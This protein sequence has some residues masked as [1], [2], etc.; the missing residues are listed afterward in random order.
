MSG[1]KVDQMVVD[2]SEDMEDISY[3]SEDQLYGGGDLIFG[4]E[5][6]LH[7]EVDGSDIFAADELVLEPDFS[8]VGSFSDLS[9][10]LESIEEKF[11][12]DFPDFSSGSREN[13]LISNQGDSQIMVFDS[14]T[15]TTALVTDSEIKAGTISGD[16]ALFVTGGRIELDLLG[17]TTTTFVENLSDIEIDLSG[18]KG[19]MILSVLGDSFEE[20]EYSFQ[21][22]YLFRGE[23]KLSV[24]FGDLDNYQGNIIINDVQ[25]NS[26]QVVV[27]GEQG[28]FD[29]MESELRDFFSISDQE[30]DVLDFD[31]FENSENVGIIL[32]VDDSFKD[33]DLSELGANIFADNEVFINSVNFENGESLSPSSDNQ[34]VSV[35]GTEADSLSG[36]EE[37][38]A[39][40]EGSGDQTEFESNLD[41][42]N[43]EV[44]D[45]FL[46][47][48]L[49]SAFIN[50]DAI[51]IILDE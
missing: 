38:L 51:D 13:I 1:D 24:H 20:G 39:Q 37:L 41:Q 22:G 18:S 34:I 36:A 19:D 7:L 5:N 8:N 40:Y 29:D 27:E 30:G 50:E 42:Q 43:Q 17:G 6:E 31:S 26:M 4:V 3:T 32:E 15:P 16:V 48:D 49:V 28:V 47:N 12:V 33:L 14:D 45:D 21:E 11:G 44:F 23:E 2:K 46:S 9:M 10:Y 25:S 35:G